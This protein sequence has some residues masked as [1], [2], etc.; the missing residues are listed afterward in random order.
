LKRWEQTDDVLQNATPRLCRA[1]RET[2]PPTVRDFFRLAALH[3]RRE[4]ID[5]ARHHY[6]PQGPAARHHT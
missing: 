6:G 4:L 3:V 1:L 2:T 5:L